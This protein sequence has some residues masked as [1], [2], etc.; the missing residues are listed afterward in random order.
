[1]CIVYLGFVLIQCIFI[2][3]EPDPLDLLNLAY[4]YLQQFKSLTGAL[5]IILQL[6]EWRLLFSMVNFQAG[7]EVDQL[8]IKRDVYF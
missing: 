1:M 5:I 6:L 7:H 4:R 2:N 3:F 8:L